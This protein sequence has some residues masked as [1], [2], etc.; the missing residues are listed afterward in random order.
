MGGGEGRAHEGR[1]RSG[2]NDLL[3][4]LRPSFQ[5]S[6]S[7]SAPPPSS[8]RPSRPSSP[9]ASL[10]SPPPQLINFLSLQHP[11]SS[12][13]YAAFVARIINSADQRASIFLQQKLTVRLLPSSAPVRYLSFLSF[14]RVLPGRA[15]AGSAIGRSSH[16]CG[17]WRPSLP[18]SVY[19][20]LTRRRWARAVDLATDCSGCRVLQKA[21]DGAEE[22]L[23]NN[24]A[25]H[26]WSKI[27]VLSWS[28]RAPPIFPYVNKALACHETR[29]LL[30]QHASENLEERAG[31]AARCLARSRR[32]MAGG[33]RI[34]SKTPSST[35]TRDS[36]RTR[37]GRHGAQEGGNDALDRVVR[38]MAR[39]AMIVDLALSLTG[40]VLPTG[41]LI[42]SLRFAPPS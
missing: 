40:S 24:H 15:G 35:C 2:G 7:P 1:G 14:L 21:L 10:T 36:S 13:P 25:A 34:A 41:R 38:R 19:R 8:Y 3:P 26:V 20:V 42:S 23:V 16:A 33:A 28:P 22:T 6:R 30:V 31:G 9:H 27:M 32:V 17:I 11:A 12:P 18:L 29:S 39:R 5:I 37:R 4:S